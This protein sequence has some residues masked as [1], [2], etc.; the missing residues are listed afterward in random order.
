MIDVSLTVSAIKDSIGNIMGASAIVRDITESKRMARALIEQKGLA[1]LGEMAAIVAHEV[2]NPLAGIGGAIQV[3]KGHFP[4]GS[5]DCLITQEILVLPVS[6]EIKLGDPRRLLV[7][8]AKEWGADSIFLGA[9]GLNRL[10]R[11]LLGSVAT[12]VVTR[13]HCSVEIV[14]TNSSKLDICGPRL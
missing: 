1:R 8:E 2:K 13:A 14:R 12:A 6:S 4:P 7:D 9:T 10:E 3:I 11:F 5:P